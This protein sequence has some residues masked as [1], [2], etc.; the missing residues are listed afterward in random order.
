[1]SRL[2]VLPFMRLIKQR[3]NGAA[4]TKRIQH[5]A[6]ILHGLSIDAFGEQLTLLHTFSLI[7]GIESYPVACD[8][9]AQNLFALPQ[10][11]KDLIINSAS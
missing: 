6:Q 7:F 10:L 8:F 5:I 4:Q 3:V 11:E 1:M 2:C 9:N